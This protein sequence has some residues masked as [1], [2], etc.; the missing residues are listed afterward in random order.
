MGCP[1]ILQRQRAG[2]LVVDLQVKLFDKMERRTSVL[3]NFRLLAETAKTLELEV[4]IT[5]QYP[6]GIGPSD[7][8]VLEALPGVKPLVK[9]SFS[10]F[11]GEGFASR[12]REMDVEQ[13]IITGIES[14]VCV[15][16]TALDAL[17]RGYGVFIAGDAVCSRSKLHWR[18]AL[19]ALSRAGAFV[20]PTETI[21][22]QLL[23]KS[24]T[25]AFKKLLKLIK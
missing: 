11:D 17:D 25:P 9:E 14:H 18:W 3:N 2:L 16:Q 23:E 24:G 4:V 5:E 1:A 19:E 10:C 20:L 22:F 8:A 12:L 21:V 15:Y 6:E 13:L 7:P